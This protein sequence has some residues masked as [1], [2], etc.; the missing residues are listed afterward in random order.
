[1]LFFSYSMLLS[2]WKLILAWTLAGL[3]VYAVAMGQGRRR[4]VDFK[5]ILGRDT[6]EA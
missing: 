2:S 1:M 4:G 5:A 6:E 3:V